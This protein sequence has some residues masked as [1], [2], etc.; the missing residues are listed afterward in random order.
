MIFPDSMPSQWWWYLLPAYLT[1]WSVG[2]GLWNFVDGQGMF[3]QFGIDFTVNSP[4]KSFILKNSAARYLGIALALI[5]GVWLVRTPTAALTAL[6]ARLLMDILDW[7]AGLQTGILDKP[8]TGSLQSFLM[9]VGPGLVSI[10]LLFI[11]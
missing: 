6:A 8:L 2:F 3:K 1:L 7:V 9:F 10:I 5:I 11:L 4:V